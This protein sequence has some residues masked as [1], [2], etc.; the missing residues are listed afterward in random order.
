[1]IPAALLCAARC[2]NEGHGMETEFE[3]GEGAPA[4]KG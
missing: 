1:M 2:G 3:A 4:G